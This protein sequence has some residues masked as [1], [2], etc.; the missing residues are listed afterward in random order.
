MTPEELKSLA[1]SYRFCKELS[2]K[3]GLPIE[4]DGRVIYTPPRNTEQL[5]TLGLSETPKE[6][7]SFL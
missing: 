3:L 7:G 1:E 4:E 6:N 5:I 2:D